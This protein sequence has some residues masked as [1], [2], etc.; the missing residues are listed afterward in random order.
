[1]LVTAHGNGNYFGLWNNEGLLIRAVSTGGVCKYAFFAPD[2]NTIV[3]VEK[4]SISY[5]DI[6]GQLIERVEIPGVPTVAGIIKVASSP[7]RTT[8]AATDSQMLF[9]YDVAQRSGI[10]LKGNNQNPSDCVFS[11]DGKLLALTNGAYF[12]Q[13]ITRDG[14]IVRNFCAPGRYLQSPFFDWSGSTVGA[15]CTFMNKTDWKKSQYSAMRWNMATG[16]ALPDLPRKTGLG[17]AP[18][19]F[20]TP[21]DQFFVEC[22]G[23]LM[24]YYDTGNNPV[25]T[26]L[27][28]I[29][30]VT[31]DPK[32]TWMAAGGAGLM[33]M[34][35]DGNL[36][37]TQGGWSDNNK[38]VVFDEENNLYR[39]DMFKATKFGADGSVT[40][41]GISPIRRRSDGMLA[42]GTSFCMRGGIWGI[43]YADGL[44]RLM[45][46]SGTLL[47]EIRQPN[48]LIQGVSLGPR[49]GLVVA[50]MSLNQGQRRQICFWDRNS[51]LRKAV[52][53]KDLPIGNPVCISQD[54]NLVAVCDM[55]SGLSI[56]DP[57]GRLIAN[58]RMG[59]GY[60]MLH[61][62]HFS[63]DGQHVAVLASETTLGTMETNFKDL[64][65]LTLSIWN[66]NA[67]RTARIVLNSRRGSES[68]E[69]FIV[70]AELS[71]D[72]ATLAIGY[73]F[74]RVELWS[75]TG[76]LLRS[77][78]VGGNA[79][80]MGLA[81]SKNGNVLAIGS[82][83]E[84]RL[85]N[86]TTD[87][88]I[89][90]MTQLT[91]NLRGD[92]VELMNRPTPIPANIHFFDNIQENMITQLA[93]GG[94][95]WIMFTPEGYF[96]SSRYG[97]QLVGMGRETQAVAI[98]QF[99]LKYNRPDQVL[100]AIGLADATTIAHYKNLWQRRLKHAGL[101]ESD[102]DM[103]LNP[104][105]VSI[106]SEKQDGHFVELE[107]TL[108]AEPEELTSYNVFVN[109]VPL[110]GAGGNPVAGK[111]ETLH[112]RVELTHGR[113]KVE[114]TCRNSNGCESYRALR[115]F[116][117][118]KI[119]KG[120]L[121]YLGFG[122]SKYKDNTLDLK[123]AAQDASDL[124]AVLAGMKT[125]Y[126]NIKGK[127]FTDEL[128]TVANIKRAKKLLESLSV[129]DTLVLFIAGH[130]LYDRDQDNTY[131][132][133][134]HDADPARLRETA[135]PFELIEDLLQGIPPRNKLFLM[136]TCESGELEDRTVSQFA[137]T[138]KARGFIPRSIRGLKAV[139]TVS[140]T[141][142]P[143]RQRMYTRDRF[144]YNDLFRRSG[145]IVFSSS[146]GGELSYESDQL[147]N[148]FFT[149][150]VINALAGG[151][152]DE[153]NDG[154]VSTD[155]L[156]R[157][158]SK[159]V[160][161]WSSG[162]QNPTI[163]RDNIYQ[164][165]GFPSGGSD[166]KN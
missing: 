75:R 12:L 16:S 125:N 145:A 124:G 114:V 13:I 164:Q 24:T 151:K 27:R 28:P 47:R 97:G 31:F 156:Y 96:D 107:M 94:T 154:T 9:I 102:L 126:G 92:Y 58:G 50:S 133:M 89:T 41:T 160:S 42:F 153:N 106:I 77:C 159:T 60:G 134:T 150:A 161:V 139:E 61:F 128:V 21:G 11:P 49:S 108:K 23:S 146:Q 100:E 4:N 132:F 33:L 67:Q 32:G 66:L 55:G 36:V 25:K 56:Y 118:S 148:G 51:K 40:P 158:V 5:W 64:K 155:E 87:K 91:G 99:A 34:N 6:M 85:W 86:L 165:F 76:K 137:S 104:P 17:V 129:E 111:S 1:M 10:V 74:G 142:K 57:N 39:L 7:D 80:P 163:D 52:D 109:D 84:T 19:F 113:N 105:S 157:Y 140:T 101:T 78:Q 82:Y 83:G 127:V 3:A 122:V 73:N 112:E 141:P 166:I 149:Q 46:N 135:A 30:T 103:D 131:Y 72:G 29:A 43:G 110:H 63:P 59:S 54:E 2:A 93:A 22:S 152:G 18:R 62:V 20:Y 45:D 65:E 38:R 162:L 79:G 120:S 69:D 147:K 117:C 81:F 44:V 88:Y 130:G 95:E 14:R 121:Y 68:L 138:A 53:V 90:L 48:A 71:Y 35:L 26:M 116:D 115:W 70:S 8:I 119:T 37:R 15:T 144:I 123:Y 143:I 136:D 98:D